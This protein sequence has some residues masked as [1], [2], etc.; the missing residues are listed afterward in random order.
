MI[1]N[2][3]L[4]LGQTFAKVDPVFLMNCILKMIPKIINSVMGGLQTVD[5]AAPLSVTGIGEKR[6]ALV[7]G[8]F[9]PAAHPSFFKSV[10][11]WPALFR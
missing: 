2:I 11:I 7:L 4:E 9:F 3:V 5:I 10:G 6:E 8:S 1:K